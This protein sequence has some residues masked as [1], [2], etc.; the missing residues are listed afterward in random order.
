MTRKWLQ[1][2]V[3]VRRFSECVC[4][5]LA[6]PVAHGHTGGRAEIL[7]QDVWG[8]PSGKAGFKVEINIADLGSGNP[9]ISSVSLG[10]EIKTVS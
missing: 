7:A 8:T 4:S 9:T 3:N 10:Q 6:A 5:H 2:V 1:T